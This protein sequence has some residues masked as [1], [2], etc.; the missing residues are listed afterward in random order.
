MFEL[1][2]M[3]RCRMREHM[4]LTLPQLEV[5]HFVEYAKSPAMSTVAA[6]LKIKAPSATALIGE[7]VALGMLKRTA[8]AHDRRQIQVTLTTKGIR[9]L[10]ESVE[11][12]TQVISDM[13]AHLSARDKEE[14]ARILEEIVSADHEATRLA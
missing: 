1:G 2:R 14:F 5:L 12:R 8:D 13:L 4:A 6:H 7:M 3:V 9:L 10:G 11:R